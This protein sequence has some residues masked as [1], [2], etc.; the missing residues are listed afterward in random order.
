MVSVGGWAGTGV[1]LQ[2]DGRRQMRVMPP[3]SCS[4]VLKCATGRLLV[5]IT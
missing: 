2:I 3:L 5:G 1:N 4:G